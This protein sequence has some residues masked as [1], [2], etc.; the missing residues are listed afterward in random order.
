MNKNIER[1]GSGLVGAVLILFVGLHWHIAIAAWLS[2]ILLIRS[3][4]LMGR[5]YETLPILAATA[6]FRLLSI[7]GGWDMPLYM[8]FVFSLLVLLP[9][10]TALYIDRWCARS[11]KRLGMLLMFP[12]VYT[13]SDF[14]LGFSPVGT[15]FSPAAGQFGYAALVQTVSLT[16]LWGLTFLIGLTATIVNL[17]WENNFDLRR[18]GRPVIVLAAVFAVVL[19]YGYS[20]NLLTRPAAGTVRIAGVTETHPRDYWVITDSGTPPESKTEYAEELN[21][22]NDRLFASSQRAADYGAKIIFWS[23]GN[24]VMYEDDLDAFLERAQA[25]AQENQVY[26]APTPLVLHY[27]RTKNDNLVLL[28]GPDGDALFRYEKTISWYPTES[29]G[30]VPAV[31]TPWGTLSSV[32]CFDLDFPSLLRQAYSRDVDILLVPG[33]DTELISPY[34]T[35]IGLLRGIEYGFSTFRHANKS[36]SIAADYAGNTLAYQNYFDT[37]DRVMIADLP[38]KGIK[39]LYGELGDWFIVLVW[40][41]LAAAVVL[42]LRDLVRQRDRR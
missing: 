8:E 21:A 1:F 26:F 27:G 40:A 38:I 19:A 4:R 13:A 10:W 32:I 14:L 22:I 39:T 24:A 12:L 42:A 30:I 33:F 35:Q 41:A 28:F 16:G 23:E 9:L 34:H 11:G 25:F 29:D 15:V 7:T 6:L 5:W 2:P 31:E 36:T 17:T 3:F 18:A 20:K 37:D